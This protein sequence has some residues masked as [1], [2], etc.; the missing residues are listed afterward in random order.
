M[1]RGER[2]FTIIEALV[3]LVIVAVALPALLR[4]IAIQ[5]DGIGIMRDKLHAQW[6][7]SYVIESKK[8]YQGGIN[9]RWD[10]DEGRLE[11]L[12]RDW[13]WEEEQTETSLDGF[14]EY[15]LTIRLAEGEQVIYEARRYGQ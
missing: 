10:T 4:L 5:A 15:R 1:T 9:R 11:M 12:G 3:A 2:G 13:R 6:V 7:A 8:L 14:F